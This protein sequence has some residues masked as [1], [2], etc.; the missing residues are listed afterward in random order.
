M[1]L[2]SSSTIGAVSR[3]VKTLTLRS[4]RSINEEKETLYPFATFQSTESV[5]L[6]SP[7]SICASILRD[8]PVTFAAIS[9]VSF[10][11]SRICL[12]FFDTDSLISKPAP[13]RVDNILYE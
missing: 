6:T 10:F 1:N 9:S 3:M 5:G 11:A 13:P 4:A 8:T 2:P 7:F 12:I